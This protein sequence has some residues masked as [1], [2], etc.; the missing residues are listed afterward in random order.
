VRLVRHGPAPLPILFPHACVGAGQRAAAKEGTAAP[1]VLASVEATN[2][3]P[4]YCASSG[5]S[6]RIRGQ[7]IAAADA[8]AVVTVARQ[9]GEG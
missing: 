3:F 6:S 7:T 8:L 2:L 9:L 1:L 4:L 5:K